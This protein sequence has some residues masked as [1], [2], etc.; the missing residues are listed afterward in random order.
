MLERRMIHPK[1]SVALALAAGIAGALAAGAQAAVPP[2]APIASVGPVSSPGGAVTASGT[3]T[4]GGKA[5][6]CL[7]DQHS[8]ANP[9]GSQPAQIND[10]SC[11][12]SSGA[13]G[14]GSASSS[15]QSAGSGGAQSGTASKSGARSG[16]AGTT[17]PK[18]GAVKTAS[19]TAAQARGLRITGIRYQ[20]SS[21]PKTHKLGVSVALR[22]ELGRPIR[23]AV[24]TL[25]SAPGVTPKLKTATASTNALGTAHFSVPTTSKMLGKRLQLQIGAR[26]PTTRMVRLASV[27]L[28]HGTLPCKK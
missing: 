20:T 23:G 11:K 16:A 1:R 19:V 5:D 6:A 7:N 25:G 12:S 10:R 15:S 17:S 2:G 9:S 28:P 3:A 27:L 22:D 18:S 21:V 14:A 13:A 26:T 4:S 8:G 24:V